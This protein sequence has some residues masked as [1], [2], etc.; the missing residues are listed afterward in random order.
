MKKEKEI[1]R[2]WCVYGDQKT[3]LGKIVWESP[4]GQSVQISYIEDR[5]HAS[6]TWNKGSDFTKRFDTLYKAVVEQY[7]NY[8]SLYSNCKSLRSYLEDA[9]IKFPGQMGTESEKS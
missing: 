5:L 4:D 8:H 1:K 7:N 2:P 6:H 9:E 3:M